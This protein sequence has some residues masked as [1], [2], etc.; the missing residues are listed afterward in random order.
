MHPWKGSVTTWYSRDIGDWEGEGYGAWLHLANPHPG[1]PLTKHYSSVRFEVHRKTLADVLLPAAAVILKRM[2]RFKAKIN[3]CR[4]HSL[5]LYNLKL[6]VHDVGR[7][8]SLL[9]FCDTEFLSAV[10]HGGLVSLRSM[11]L[12]K[13]LH[14]CAQ[15]HTLEAGSKYFCRARE[16]LCSISSSSGGPRLA[17]QHPCRT[18]SQDQPWEANS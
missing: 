6:L 14:P 9:S 15:L 16:A 11:N 13:P 18:M 17:L 12:Y 1:A 4:K 8:A 7:T 2:A 5:S 3:A 10:E